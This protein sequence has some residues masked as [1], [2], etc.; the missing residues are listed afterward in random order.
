MAHPHSGKRVLGPGV[1]VKAAGGNLVEAEVQI[2]VWMT[3]L[4]MWA[5]AQ[6]KTTQGLPPYTAV[7]QDWKFYIAI[8]VEGSGVLKEVVGYTSVTCLVTIAN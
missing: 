8:G 6:R 5:F 2:G 4:L 7:G 1:E 3:G